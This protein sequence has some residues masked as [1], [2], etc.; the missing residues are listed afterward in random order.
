[1]ERE[2]HNCNDGN[3]GHGD[4]WSA[5]SWDTWVEQRMLP[6]GSI[7]SSDSTQVCVLGSREGV[8]GRGPSSYKDLEVGETLAL[9][10]RDR[11]SVWQEGR[12]SWEMVVFK[13]SDPGMHLSGRWRCRQSDI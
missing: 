1:M 6:G 10:N 13:L 9:A 12:V 8:P 4:T 5:P 2:H 11:S 3:R 7:H